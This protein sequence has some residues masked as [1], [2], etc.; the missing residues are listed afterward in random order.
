MKNSNINISL[1]PIHDG[2]NFT[3][4]SFEK[5]NEGA[6]IIATNGES[7]IAGTMELALILAEIGGSCEIEI[8]GNSDYIAILNR[9]AIINYGEGKCFVGSAV[10]IKKKGWS[11]KFLVG[12]DYDEAEREFMSRL[13]TM[14]SDGEEFSALEID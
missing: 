14:V 3:I 11:F 8:L 13:I 7:R 9:D 6:L 5:M 12:D 4:R 1:D 10:I 2:M